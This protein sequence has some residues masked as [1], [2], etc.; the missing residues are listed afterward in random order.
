MFPLENSIYANVTQPIL[1]ANTELFQWK[2]NIKRMKRLD[3]DTIERSIV[4]LKYIF[5]R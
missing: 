1:F 2:D 5:F 3:S 4:T